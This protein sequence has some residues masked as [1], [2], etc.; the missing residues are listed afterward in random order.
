MDPSSHVD[1]RKN[2]T[3]ITISTAAILPLVV[4]GQVDTPPTNSKYIRTL[5]F[6][7]QNCFPLASQPLHPPLYFKAGPTLGIVRLSQ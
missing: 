3:E 7:A 1:C 5:Q 6:E 4:L 2:T